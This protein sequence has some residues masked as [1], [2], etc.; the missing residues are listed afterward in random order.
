MKAKQK[1]Y[2]LIN[3]ISAMDVFMN[4]FLLQILTAYE[5]QNHTLAFVGS[6]IA[7]EHTVKFSAEMVDGS[8]HTA[9]QKVNDENK[10]TTDECAMI[11][12][13]KHT[14]NKMFHENVYATG[15]EIQG[16]LHFFNEDSTYEY[17]LDE[18]L[19][20]VLQIMK[21]LFRST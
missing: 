15:L 20:D 16:V 2:E 19:V 7:L 21:K 13:L 12:F 10:I 9:L 17:L 5:N 8:F 6:V 1:I 11:N 18:Y 4:I 14:R 3:S